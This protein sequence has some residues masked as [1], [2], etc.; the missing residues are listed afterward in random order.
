M[1]NF[2]SLEKL[3]GALANIKVNE[4]IKS[5]QKQFP[6]WKASAVEDRVRLVKLMLAVD[7]DKHPAR[8]PFYAFVKNIGKDLVGVDVAFG[9]ILLLSNDLILSCTNAKDKFRINGVEYGL[10]QNRKGRKRYRPLN[11][12]PRKKNTNL[13]HNGDDFL[14]VAND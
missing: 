1:S 6:D 8:T 4:A 2:I 11:T 10:F 3:N 13:N 9:S 7:T 14:D 5:M 12:S